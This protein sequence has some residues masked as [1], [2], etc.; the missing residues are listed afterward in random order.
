MVR[1]SLALPCL[2][3]APSLVTA[4]PPVKPRPDG[5]APLPAGAIARLGNARFVAPDTSKAIALSPDGKLVATASGADVHIWDVDAARIV[6]V[7]ET[8]Y[9]LHEAI[10]YSPSF[11]LRWSKDG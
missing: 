1:R 6:R 8:G 2:L 11:R 9:P 4:L 3:L 10:P 5:G 7:Y